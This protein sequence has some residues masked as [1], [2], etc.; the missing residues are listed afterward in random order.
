VTVGS[1]GRFMAVVIWLAAVLGATVAGAEGSASATGA[2]LDFAESL[3]QVGQ[4]REAAVE[5]LRYGVEGPSED[6][7]RQR[8]VLKAAAAYRRAGSIPVALRCVAWFEARPGL[9]DSLRCAASLERALC[10]R[11]QGEHDRSLAVLAPVAFPVRAG[12]PACARAAVLLATGEQL[13]LRRWDAADSTIAAAAARMDSAAGS[14]AA[15][16]RMK[17]LL[18]RGRNLKGPSSGVAGLLSALVPGTGRLYAGRRAE[19]INSFLVTGVATWQ[20]VAGFR[21]RG[22]ESLR[23]WISGA[24]ALVLYGGDVYGSCV[25]ARQAREAMWDGYDEEVDGATGTDDRP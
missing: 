5:F 15:L 3:L 8:A 13:H 17:E 18:T 11:E 24:T 16:Q 21:D 19:A 25:A 9:T 2:S 14:V 10:L 6:A 20:C 23:G 7:E 12:D 22:R 4:Y 1:P